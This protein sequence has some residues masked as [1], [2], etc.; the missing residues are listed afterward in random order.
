MKFINKI[1]ILTALITMLLVTSCD[2]KELEQIN[3]NSPTPAVLLSEEG[4]VRAGLGI[5]SKFG[6]EYFWLALSG[7]NAMGENT[8]MSVGNF[9]WRWMNQPTRIIL[10]NGTILTPPQGASQSEE[11]KSRNARAFGNDNVFFNEWVA[12]YLVNNQANLIL[13]TVDDPQLTLS[14]DAAT[15]ASKK[16][17]LKAWAHWW[18][19]FA[20]SRIGSLYVAGIITDKVDPSE[21]GSDGA[22]KTRQEVIAE[23]Q[24]Q[25]D[26]AI[27]ELDKVTVTSA[28]TEL[29]GRMV[30]DQAKTSGNIAAGKEAWNVGGVPSVAAWKRIMNTYKARNILVNKKVGEVTTAEWNQILTLT[31]NGVQKTDRVFAMRTA[32]QNTVLANSNAGWTPWRIL[33]NAWEFLSERWVQEFKPGDARF[34]RNVVARAT[35]I[36]NNSGRGFQYGTRWAL[37]PIEQG[38]DYASQTVGLAEIPLATTYEENALTRAEALINTGQ[39]EPGLQL[40]DEVRQFQ[41]AQLPAVAG[42]GLTLA[43]AREELYRERRIALFLKGTAFYDYRRFGFACKDCQRT[44]AV[45]IA[46]GG[47]V[48]N[49]ATIVYNYMD[50]WDVPA[51]EI[52][53]NKPA[54]GSAPVI[55]PM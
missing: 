28:Y 52:D 27:A 34:T 29:M 38:G 15:V 25:F 2:K 33:T 17:T 1:K 39:I 20:Y 3:P 32:D 55:F 48:D 42:T 18:K 41:N 11:L 43:Q 36:V 49:N 21:G 8:F 54:S 23:A 40:I 44:G 50:Y 16:A 10:S 19:G 31:A 47:I 46:Q 37:K 24:S 7:H 4:I 30:P 45:V 6:L 35:T 51:N 14:G 5:Y 12:M 26:K 9:S 22:Y 13:R 53:F